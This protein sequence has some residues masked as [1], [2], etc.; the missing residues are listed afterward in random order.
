[1]LSVFLT[2]SNITYKVFIHSQLKGFWVIPQVTLNNL[3]VLKKDTENAGN[4]STIIL[5]SCQAYNSFMFRN[6]DLE[7]SPSLFN[8]VHRKFLL[9]YKL[10]DILS[11]VFI[12]FRCNLELVSN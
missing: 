2:D 5:L 10:F 7:Y 11:D 8:L 9:G 4:A 6:L 3:E 12:C 1:M